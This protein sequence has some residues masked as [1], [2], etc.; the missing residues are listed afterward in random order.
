M[1]IIFSS[2]QGNVWII[3]TPSVTCVIK[4][5]SNLRGEI[6][7]RSLKKWYELYFECKVGDQD[8]SWAP[9]IYCVT[10]VRLLTGWVNGSR[11]RPFYFLIVW[12][13]PKDR[14]SDCY[15]CL[16]NITG[17]TSKSKNTVK[18]PDLPSAMRPVPHSEELWYKSPGK[19]FSNENS[20]CDEDHEQEEGDNVDCDPT[21]VASCSSSGSHLLTH[22]KFV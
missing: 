3:L 20:D 9:H 16:T 6:L 5:L 17:I 19:S 15:F 7:L 11:Q 1:F 8:K 18:Y 4:W 12:R 14:W 22:F 10:C 2:C 21:F 13:E